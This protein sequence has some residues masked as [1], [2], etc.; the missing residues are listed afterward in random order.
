MAANLVGW[1]HV[2]APL[3]E[4]VWFVVAHRGAGGSSNP[5]GGYDKQRI[6]TAIKGLVDH[7]G[8]SKPITLVCHDPCMPVGYAF[9]T[10]F[11][12]AVK[13]LVMMRRR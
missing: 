10:L 9:A 8:V 1:R 3:R 2:I 5:E 12:E 6:A 13:R 11:P 7:I 4:D